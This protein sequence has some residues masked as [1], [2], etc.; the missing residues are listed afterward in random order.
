M[1]GAVRNRIHCG[2]ARS[3]HAV[4]GEIDME[5]CGQLRDALDTNDSPTTII[6]LSGVTFMNSSGLAVLIRA[7]ENLATQ[8][9]NSRYKRRPRRSGWCA[10]DPGSTTGSTNERNAV[11]SNALLARSSTMG[12]SSSSRRYTFRPISSRDGQSNRM[13]RSTA[14]AARSSMSIPIERVR[15]HVRFSA[16]HGVQPSCTVQ[17]GRLMTTGGHPSKREVRRLADISNRRAQRHTP[18]R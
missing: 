5:N 8:A 15:A 18:E 10:A 11:P 2:R 13:L 12:S 17:P 4:C 9:G 3:A 6:D 16:S 1:E 14:A 7:D